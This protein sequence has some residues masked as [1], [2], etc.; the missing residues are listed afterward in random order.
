MA[1]QLQML[2]G[3]DGVH[4]GPAHLLW[5]ATGAGAAA[6]GLSDEVGDLKVGKSADFVLLRAPA[7]STLSTVLERSQSVEDKLGALFTLA[8]E[9]SIVEVRVAGRVV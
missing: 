9:E 5:L 3:S 2:A 7:G 1:Y 4:L 8:R 6:L